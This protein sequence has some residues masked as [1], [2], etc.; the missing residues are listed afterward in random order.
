M[1]VEELYGNNC[2]IAAT[3]TVMTSESSQAAV[4]VAD[5]AEEDMSEEKMDMGVGAE[6]YVPAVTTGSPV[7]PAQNESS[8]TL[9]LSATNSA[10]ELES[11]PSSCFVPIKLARWIGLNNSNADSSKTDSSTLSL[12]MEDEAKAA[13]EALLQATSSTSTETLDCSAESDVLVQM[14]T[15]IMDAMNGGMRKAKML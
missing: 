5:G 10:K 12:G 7:Q 1:I 2:E 14:I 3:E 11:S 13:V 8:E 9:L 4:S 15:N 6:Q